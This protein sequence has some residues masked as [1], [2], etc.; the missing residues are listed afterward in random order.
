MKQQSCHGVSELLADNEMVKIDTMTV[1]NRAVVNHIVEIKDNAPP[2]EGLYWISEQRYLG[3][4][5][6]SMLVP[7]QS[8]EFC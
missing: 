6:L 5:T 2:M 3:T 1:P 4:H 8:I 7:C